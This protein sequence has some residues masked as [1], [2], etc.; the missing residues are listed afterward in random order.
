M[1]HFG[2][3]AQAVIQ[4]DRF[5]G[6]LDVR[7]SSELF[8]LLENPDA[9]FKPRL[10]AGAV[11][12][13]GRWNSNGHGRLYLNVG[14][15]GLNSAGFR[16]WVRNANVRPV[17]LI[18]DLIP[19]THPKFC[20]TGETDKHRERMRTVL[21]SAAG[22]IG[23]SQSTLDELASFARRERLPIPPAMAAW[24]GTDPLQPPPDI[25]PPEHPIFV[26]IGTIEARKNHLLL[27]EI[28]SRLIDRLGAAAPRLNII[29]QRG[30]EAQDVFD[31]LDRSE[32]LR[33][34]VN[35]VSGCSDQEVA[36][37]LGSARALLFPSRA[38]GFGLP[39][40]EAF[41]LGV[42]VIA[43]DLP[44]FRELAGDIPTYLD[45]LDAAGWERTILDYAR[46][47]ST[48][49]SKQIGRI[50]SFRLPNWNSHF[51]AVESWLD[52]LSGT[53]QPDQH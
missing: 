20:R 3:E 7:S 17:Y 12:N 30:W 18:H 9:S 40:I 23:N 29:G 26:T 19:I 53:T 25:D 39:L 51:A 11:R 48:S 50:K 4:H 8:A 46:P 38:E 28:W 37:Q 1:R 10:M 27:L 42:P 43:S 35:E 24:L 45:P 44:V 31:L 34:H 22:V 52:G 21:T 6:I 16:R 5:R 32:K 47:D 33:G 41:G 15:T 36:R 49:R 14:H 2:P 13:F